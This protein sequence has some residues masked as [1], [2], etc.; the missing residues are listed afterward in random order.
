M[1]KKNDSS[2]SSLEEKP[3]GD[4]SWRSQLC[5]GLLFLLLACSDVFTS[6]NSHETGP[7]AWLYNLVNSQFG[8]YGMTYGKAILGSILLVKALNGRR[9]I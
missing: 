9:K 7:W 6:L 4:T 2:G 8:P 1:F 3:D 5:L